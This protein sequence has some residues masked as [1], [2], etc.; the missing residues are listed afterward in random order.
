MSTFLSD[1]PTQPWK[2]VDPQYRMQQLGTHLGTPVLALLFTVISPMAG[3]TG[4]CVTWLAFHILSA[5]LLAKFG[6]KQK[7]LANAFL[8]VFVGAAIFVFTTF[9]A[10][11][12]WPVISNGL[13]GV[14]H[15]N[16]L[17]E[18]AAKVG[19]DEALNKG[20]LGHAIVG[21]V[22]MVGIATLISVPIGI[23]AALYVT[24]VRG[25]LTPFVRFFVQAMSGVPSIVAGLFIYS[26]LIVSGILQYSGFA[27]AL[28]LSILM[29]PTVARTAEEILRLI[30]DDLRTAALALGGT[31]WRTVR[32]VVLPA[33]KSGLITSAILGVARV[34]GETAPLLLTAFGNNVLNLNPF[35]ESMSALPS[36]VF[37]QML[38]GGDN[39]MA[40]AW[41]AT[42]VLLTTITILFTSARIVADRMKRN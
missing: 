37:T 29:L 7:S 39:D 18:D 42:F 1:T 11:V 17:F 25:K 41:F 34:A 20:G 22:I 40:R 13:V 8:E 12:L 26:A 10:T 28:A 27:G 32:M 5:A 6:K 4:F 9:V 31:Q 23:L 2:T 19:A 36:Y 30:P 21:T 35:S 15:L 16:L 38:L 33:A 3:F 14:T 24:E